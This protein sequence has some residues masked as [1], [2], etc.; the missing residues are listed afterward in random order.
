MEMAEAE[1]GC[2]YNMKKN[3]NCRRDSNPGAFLRRFADEL[4]FRAYE[5]DLKK[6]ISLQR[7]R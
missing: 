7:K 3:L 2:N 1:T 6:K 4:G 5:I